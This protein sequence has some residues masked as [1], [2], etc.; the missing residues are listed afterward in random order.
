MKVLIIGL[1]GATWNVLDDSL[2]GQHMPNLNKL[3]SSGTSGVLHSTEPPITAASWTTC[4]TGCHPHTHGIIGWHEYSCSEDRLRISTSDSCKVPNIWQE[5][6][7]QGLKVASINVPWTFP[8]KEVNG[9]MIAGYGCPGPESQFTYPVDFKDELLKRIPDY[10]I[11]AKWDK[12]KTYSPDELDA[13]MTRVER[14]F[15][16]RVE[17]AKLV[18]EKLNW[19]V[20]MIQ[21]HDTDLIEHHIWPYLDKTTRDQY[22]QQRDRVFESYERLDEAV[23]EL[24]DLISTKESMVVVVSDHGLCRKVARVKPNVMLCQWGY[25]ESKGKL[26]TTIQRRLRRSFDSSRS[27]DG[28]KSGIKQPK[29]YDFKWPDSKAMVIDTAVNG[30]LFINVKDR[31]PDGIVEPGTEYD[32]LLEELRERF[33]NAV[34]PHTGELIFSKVGTPAEIYDFSDT[35]TTM[36]GDLVLVPQPGIELVLSDSKDGEYIEMTRSDSLMGAHCY[37]GIYLFSGRNIKNSI[38]EQTHIVNIAPTI[39]AAL[40]VELPMYMDGSVLGTLFEKEVPV[41]YQKSRIDVSCRS[42]D[43]QVLSTEEEAEI[44]KRLSALGYV[45]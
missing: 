22:P 3:K 9:I 39:Y 28:K 24:L 21:F 30:H 37:E 8:C 15:Q 2:L 7:K 11:V 43:R 32:K 4:I 13:N 27:K 23:G 14:S 17:A 18:S 44:T 19:D 26:R 40:G 10:D 25:L 1:D 34:N 29:E 35:D 16:Q 12:S 20:M 31:Q 5:L 33:G 36:F 45:E 42:D 41:S 38:G 6:S